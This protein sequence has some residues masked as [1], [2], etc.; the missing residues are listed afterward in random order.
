M[1]LASKDLL[2]IIDTGLIRNIVEFLKE[3]LSD[4]E[5]EWENYGN[6]KKQQVREMI[7]HHNEATEIYNSCSAFKIEKIKL[8]FNELLL[9][10]KTQ[11]RN[12]RILEKSSQ[13]IKKPNTKIKI[14]E[15]TK[16]IEAIKEIR[17]REDYHYQRT[18][19]CREHNLKFD[20]V[21][22]QMMEQELRQIARQM[23]QL[24]DTGYIS[25]NND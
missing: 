7:L 4:F 14:M 10:W 1:K 21:Y 2:N 3:Q 15:N 24:F 23:E 17:K 9:F 18:I 13:N 19:W 16:A 12:G 22:H 6:E 11:N 20:L 8:P 5:N 25:I